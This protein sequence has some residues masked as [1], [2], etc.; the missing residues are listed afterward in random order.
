MDKIIV[1]NY[2]L[3]TEQ[4][5]PIFDNSKYSMIV[6]GA[7]SGKTLTLIGKVKYLLEN[8]LLKPEEIC[9]ISFTNEAVF[10]LNENNQKNCGVDVAVFT[11]HKLALDIL[12]QEHVS[13]Q[14][15]P[16]DLLSY[17]VQE[18]FQ[19]KCFGNAFLI[20]KCYQVFDY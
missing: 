6:A 8:K 4:L 19:A 7:G 16:P 17:T 13:Y 11:F 1:N 2:S 18:F 12:K 20:K 15:A 9:M 10:N 14:I 5:K 3:D